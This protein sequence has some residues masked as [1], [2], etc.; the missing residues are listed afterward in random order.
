M[1]RRLV[2]TKGADPREDS[3]H[4][5]L[6]RRRSHSA[7][8]EGQRVRA[9]ARPGRQVRRD[10]FGQRRHVAERRRAARRRR[11]WWRSPGR[12][13]RHRRRGRAQGVSAAGGRAPA[14]LTN[15][16]FFPYQPKARLN[17]SFATADVFIVSLKTRARRVHRAEQAVWRAGRGSAVHRR[18]RSGFRSGADRPRARL[19]DRRRA[20][21]SSAA[22]DGDPRAARR[23]AA[24]RAARRQRSRRGPH[25]RS[26][27]GGRSVPGRARRG[28][29]VSTPMLTS[30]RPGVASA[31]SET[32]SIPVQ[33]HPV[34]ETGAGRRVVRA[35]ALSCRRRS[36]WRSRR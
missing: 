19:R 22:G 11:R 17:D 28:G 25:L 7:R 35:S 3:R 23:S 16:R 27:A 33:A 34:G 6:G 13:D 4:P 12:R 10:A 14:R 20:R 2:E 30:T 9:R 5:Q 8:A 15:V 26:A 31:L 21:R 18:D 32:I 24:T 1:K 36:G 29:V